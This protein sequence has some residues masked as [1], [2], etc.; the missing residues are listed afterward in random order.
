MSCE[1]FYEQSQGRIILIG[2]G[3]DYIGENESSTSDR[4]DNA[5]LEN[6]PNDIREIAFVLSNLASQSEKPFVYIPFIQQHTLTSIPS[7]NY[8]N[9]DNLDK[10]FDE[11]KN[12]NDIIAKVYDGDFDESEYNLTSEYSTFG[13]EI[14]SFD[15]LNEND[16][17][18]FYYSG[19]GDQT[20]D[21]DLR[22]PEEDDEQVRE[23]VPLSW[24]SEELNSL[25]CTVLTVLDSCGSGSFIEE[26]EYSVNTI[27]T[28]FVDTIP[29]LYETFFTSSDDN[30]STT[31]FYSMASTR[32]GELS[33]DTSSLDVN[34]PNSIFSYYFLR[35]LGYENNSETEIGYMKE[36]IPALSNNR[37]S[38]DSI[39]EYIIDN[40]SRE[41]PLISGGRNGLVLFNIN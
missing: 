17:L 20:N 7:D 30:S 29:S 2:V 35:A 3:L 18:I 5:A 33:F 14:T 19:H 36:N 24:L 16:I 25:N 37:I 4:N 41:E 31:D 21:G 32:A 23:S 34:H 39:Y 12:N 9:Q 15:D 8:P 6:P 13:N 10:L 22:L 28:N 40:I 38:I 11:L 26:S 1:L 27:T